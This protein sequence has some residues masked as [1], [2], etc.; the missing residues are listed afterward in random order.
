MFTRSAFVGLGPLELSGEFH[1]VGLGESGGIGEEPEREAM[2]AG[3]ESA[4]LHRIFPAGAGSQSPLMEIQIQE[5]VFPWGQ[6]ISVASGKEVLWGIREGGG[7]QFHFQAHGHESH[8]SIFQGDG[9]DAGM[10]SGFLGFHIGEELLGDGLFVVSHQASRLSVPVA[11]L[12]TVSEEAEGLET[13]GQG[14]GEAQAGHILQFLGD[15]EGEIH[16]QG[17][18]QPER[19]LSFHGEG[20]L[21]FCGIGGLASHRQG[22][23][24]LEGTGGQRF[25]PLEMEEV[26]LFQ[27][28]VSH[29]PGILDFAEDSIV[30]HQSPDELF[31]SRLLEDFFSPEEPLIGHGSIGEVDQA[32]PVADGIFAEGQVGCRE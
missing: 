13:G 6:F 30:V 12:G 3:M 26:P 7:F 11:F 31:G 2:G 28:G 14:Q 24:F 23:I 16:L 8:P 1:P 5:D 15:V 4:F 19:Q 21:V 9:P 32:F 18:V 25:R 22:A 29:A 27:P 10:V 17:A 20:S